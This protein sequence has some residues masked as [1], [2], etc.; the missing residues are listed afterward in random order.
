MGIGGE[1]VESMGDLI[2]EIYKY[3]PGDETTVDFIRNERELSVDVV[4]QE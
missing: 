3:R 4:L 2:R 1:T